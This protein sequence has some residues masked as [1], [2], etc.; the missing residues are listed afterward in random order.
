MSAHVAIYLSPLP[1]HCRV[2]IDGREQ[3]GVRGIELRAH[4]GDDLTVVRIELLAHVEING[5][6]GAIEIVEPPLPRDVEP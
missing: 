1:M 4:V 2:L 6:P 5:E 3:L